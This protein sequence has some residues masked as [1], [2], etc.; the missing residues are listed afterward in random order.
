MN[1]DLRQIIISTVISSL[2]VSLVFLI[3]YFLQL[4]WLTVH[5][6]SDISIGALLP[7]IIFYCISTLCAVLA[8]IGSYFLC[9]SLAKRQNL[10][11][12]QIIHPRRDFAISIIPSIILS[13]LII[14]FIS[15]VLLANNYQST[16]Q[17]SS[18]ANNYTYSTPTPIPTIDG[19]AMVI[20]DTSPVPTL[21]MIKQSQ[22]AGVSTDEKVAAVRTT[23]AEINHALSTK[24]SDELYGLLSSQLTA[25][26]SKDSMAE[27]FSSLGN[28][29]GLQ[30]VDDPEISTEWATQKVSYT[31]NGTTKNYTVVLHLENGEWKLFG[32]QAD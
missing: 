5:S 27:A 3:A 20:R 31:N 29:A 32:T 17:A 2:T 28:G 1:R 18:S 6:S 13:V 15:S 8:Y 14:Y 21:V 16:S 10:N 25:V 7:L 11:G 4:S 23:V 12:I 24:N 9:V 22:V 26:F 30:V 19:D